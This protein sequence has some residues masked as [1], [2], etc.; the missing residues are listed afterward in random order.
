MASLEAKFSTSAKGRPT[1]HPENRRQLGD[2]T[3]APRQFSGTGR[4]REAW[5]DAGDGAGLGQ[6]ERVVT[7]PP[8]A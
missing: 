6:F 5:G 2:I 4:P 7:L 8:R 1:R 3:Q